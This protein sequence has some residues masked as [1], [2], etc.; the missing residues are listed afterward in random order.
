MYSWA[1]LS[2]AVLTLSAAFEFSGLLT[3][4]E[5]GILEVMLIF[6][7]GSS[8]EVVVGTRC[9]SAVTVLF[10]GTDELWLTTPSATV[11]YTVSNKQQ[12]QDKKC[13][14]RSQKPQGRVRK[15]YPIWSKCH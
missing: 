3:I 12:T 11:K 8:L 13:V 15:S 4:L 5:R 14:L 9:G 7:G 1:S 10:L 2:T 6:T